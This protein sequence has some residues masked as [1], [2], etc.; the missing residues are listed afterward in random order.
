M[1]KLFQK[2]KKIHSTKTISKLGI[3]GAFLKPPK[4]TAIV[5]LNDK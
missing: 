1:L 2:I 5:L 4:H 3:N